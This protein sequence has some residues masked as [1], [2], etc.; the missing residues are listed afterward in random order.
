[1]TEF[2]LSGLSGADLWHS[3]DGEGQDQLKPEESGV[4]PRPPAASRPFQSFCPVLAWK[5][6]GLCGALPSPCELPLEPKVDCAGPHV[7]GCA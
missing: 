7:A 2:V 3:T 5:L 1:M 4:D 6:A